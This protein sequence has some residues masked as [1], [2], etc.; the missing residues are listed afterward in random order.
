MLIKPEV[1]AGCH[2]TLSRWWGL[3]TRLWHNTLKAHVYCT[4]P[5]YMSIN[6]RTCSTDHVPGTSG[7]L[8]GAARSTT[9]EVGKRMNWKSYVIFKLCGKL[10]SIFVQIVFAVVKFVNL[11]W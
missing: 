11:L 3:G 1:S 5:L 7:R 9:G 4:C 8:F 6:V 10:S 2:Q